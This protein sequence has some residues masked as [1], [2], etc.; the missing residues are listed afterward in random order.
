MRQDYV[1]TL[2]N[3][4]ERPKTTYPLLCTRYLVDRFLILPNSLLL[5]IGCGRGDF[6]RGFLECGLRVEGV[7]IS[8]FSIKENTNSGVTIKK[9]NVFESR[10]PFPDNYADVIFSKSVIEHIH[11][12]E[13]FMN[14]TYRVLKPGGR[15]ITM[16]PDWETCHTSFYNDFSHVQPYTVRG[17]RDLL[18]MSNF[19][20]VI[21]EQFYQLPI[22]WQYPMLKIVSSV[23]RR[24]LTPDPSINNKFIRWSLELMCLGTGIK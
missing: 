9:A 15:I 13:I 19:H 3:E 8:V 1:A 20:D 7:D 16:T 12:P 2:Y 23:L 21:T 10:W 5:D 14:E 24:V 4:E 11:N 6:A 18:R 22:I 17:L